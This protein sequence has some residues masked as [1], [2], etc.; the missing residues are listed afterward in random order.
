MKERI[1][2]QPMAVN[3][4]P[5]IKIDYF[6]GE[7]AFLSNFYPAKVSFD[8]MDYPNNEAAFQ[9]QKCPERRAEFVA[10]GQQPGKQKR[11]GRKVPLRPDW[12]NVKDEVMRALCICK[13]AQNPHLAQKLLATG[14]AELVEGNYW[15][16]YY[17]GV[18]NGTGQNKLGK[19]LMEVREELRN[20]TINKPH[21]AKPG[22]FYFRTEE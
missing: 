3:V 13:F 2:R 4:N 18:C 7:Y 17:W 1:I 12:E 22:V 6:D 14:N 9:A 8:G 21:I 16:D 11:L 20:G 15:N 10:L 19:I 5:A